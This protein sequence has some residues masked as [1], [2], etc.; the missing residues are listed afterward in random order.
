MQIF[1]R[2][3]STCKL[4]R[5]DKNY[6]DLENTLQVVLAQKEQCDLIISNDKDFYSRDIELITSTLFCEKF[7]ERK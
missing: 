3:N 7:L 6:K 1:Y 5:E 4:M 2:C